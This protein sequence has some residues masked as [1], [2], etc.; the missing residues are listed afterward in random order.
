MIFAFKICILKMDITFSGQFKNGVT[1]E[2]ATVHASLDTIQVAKKQESE[3]N[4]IF[5][6]IY[7]SQTRLRIVD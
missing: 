2:K 5:H 3:R 1:N 4:R 7:L 6:R